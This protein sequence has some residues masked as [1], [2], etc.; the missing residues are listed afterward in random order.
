MKLNEVLTFL[1]KQKAIILNTIGTEGAPESRVLINIRNAQIA[2]HLKSF[3]ETNSRILA[4]TNT[5]SAK[6]S[7]IRANPLSSLYLYD[8]EWS[9]LLLIG[10]CQEVLDKKVADALWDDSWKMYYPEGKDGGDFSILE[11]IPESYKTYQNFQVKG[12]KI[13]G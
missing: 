10:K 5:H 3:F 4:I 11:F 1:D 12:G 9:G 8:Q 6:I 2:P 7:Q 13:G